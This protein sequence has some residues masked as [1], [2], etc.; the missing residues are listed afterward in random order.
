MT[1][2][3]DSNSATCPSGC[4]GPVVAEGE[5]RTGW[6]GRDA[7]I[8]LTLQEERAGAEVRLPAIPKP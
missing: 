1:A 2:G 3:V 8:F 4:Y 6:A 7:S 5:N